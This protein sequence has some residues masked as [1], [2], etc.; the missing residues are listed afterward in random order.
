MTDARI[1]DSLRTEL[2]R[3]WSEVAESAKRDILEFPPSQ[4]DRF[5]AVLF[6][7]L[8][9]GGRST[10]LVTG[11][12]SWNPRSRYY[13]ACREAARSGK[14]IV[15][16]FLVAHRHCRLMPELRDHVA[17]DKAAGIVTQVHYVGGLLASHELP[18]LDSREIGL[19]DEEIACVARYD[20]SAVSIA[21]TEW[22]VSSRAADIELQQRVFATIEA[23]AEV[24]TLEDQSEELQLEEPMV[25][26]A[27]LLQTLAPVLCRGDHVSPDNCAWYHGV[28]QYLRIFDMVSTPTWH[29]DFYAEELGKLAATGNHQNVLI[30][31][32]A[33]YSMLAH[34][35]WAYR[36]AKLPPDV[37]VMD[38]CETPL[39]LCK[40]YAKLVG[41]RVSTIAADILS[42]HHQPS[43]D[44]VTTDAFL[45]RFSPAVRPEILAKWKDWLR[46]GGMLVTTARI[47]QGL[48]SV[49]V[50]S[51]AEQ[52][53]A[54]RSR[55][56]QHARHWQGFLGLAV[57]ELAN[58]AERYAREMTS[59]SFGSMN[60]LIGLLEGGGFAVERLDEAETP[61][62]FRSTV[63]ARL[64]AQ[65]R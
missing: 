35:F 37:S 47:E 31:G 33:D 7:S 59:Y 44:V 58:Q 55:A 60:E 42:Y 5:G 52:V 10:L 53:A 13:E 29:A 46:P 16:L 48:T 28:W 54:F 2:K 18:I 41:Q 25:T 39:F 27:P 43:A 9:K 34:V 61:G 21:P 36:S 30:S 50:V 12:S 51:S 23:G 38:L 56:V 62:E 8:A 17:L 40:W 3:Y 1:F 64:V 65:R 32:T 45:T 20:S 63:Y 26:T 24:V 15:R 6:S 14:A 19:W 22:T 57:D 4:V 11:S 49:N